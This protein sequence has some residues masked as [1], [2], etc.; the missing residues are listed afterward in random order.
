MARDSGQREL[1]HWSWKQPTYVHLYICSYVRALISYQW[2]EERNEW[3]R[4]SSSSV[5]RRWTPTC[6]QRRDFRKGCNCTRLLTLASLS[7]YLFSR[8]RCKMLGKRQPQRERET[9]V[10]AALVE[11][12]T[13]PESYSLV[14][15]RFVVVWSLKLALVKK[16]HR[17]TQR[18]YYE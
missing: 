13:Q 14:G 2:E 18:L 4:A 10:G 1:T 16:V 3:L 5:G 11:M 9:L 17:S 6:L 12:V 7:R 15:R 8:S